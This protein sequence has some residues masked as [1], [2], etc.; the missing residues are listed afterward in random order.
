[1]IGQILFIYMFAALFFLFAFVAYAVEGYGLNKMAEKHERDDGWMGYLPIARRYLEGIFIGEISILGVTFKNMG[2][3]MVLVPFAVLFLL[4][5]GWVIAGIV[6]VLVQAF[7][8][9]VRHEFFK[10]YSKNAILH[11]I[12]S[13]VVPFYFSIIIAVFGVK[14]M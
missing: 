9:I 13:V 3:W 5:A 2:L 14:K 4:P 12:L 1:M 6:F 8:G 7:Y 11:A 10:R